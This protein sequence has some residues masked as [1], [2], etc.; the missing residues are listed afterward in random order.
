MTSEDL[1][2]SKVE[3]QWDWCQSARQV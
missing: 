2:T 1:N 3:Q